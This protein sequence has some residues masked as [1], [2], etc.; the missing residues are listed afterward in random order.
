MRPG[1]IAATALAL[2]ASVAQAQDTRPQQPAGQT[3]PIKPARQLRFT[4]T[5]G[6]WMSL[7]ISPDGRTIVFDL[8]GDL[9]SMAA[10][11]G[12]AT[13]I[14]GGMGFDAQ[15]A[16]AP[17]GG[18]I[19]F[20]SDR[21]GAENLWIARPDGSNARQVS[22]GDD[23]TV[24]TSPAWSTDGKS[25]F[26]SRFRADLNN[27]ELWR[28]DLTGGATLVVP[29]KDGKDRH[30][31]LGAEATR[32]G[33]YL[34]FARQNAAPVDDAITPWTIVRRDLRTGVETIL[35]AGP[36][37]RGADKEAFFRPLPSPDGKLLAYAMRRGTQTQ[38][39]LRDLE[40][41]SDRLI[42]AELDRDNA[43]ASAWQDVI[44][45][46]AFTPDGSAL[47]LT[48]AGGF[49][50]VTLDGAITRLPFEA[51]VDLDVGPT[52]R[53]RL[54]EP[55][56]PV[57]ARLIQAPAV[58]P[59]GKS[60]AFSTLGRLYIRPANG[61]IR[62]LPTPAPAFQPSWSPDGKR[63]VFV[64]WTEAGGGAVWTIDSAGAA[65]PKQIS[66]LPAYYTN[67][68]FTPDG[69]E[70]LTIRSPA[71]A[72][73]Q[74]NFDWG[75]I[76]D[77]ELAAFPK[78]GGDARVVAGGRIGGRPHF[79][80]TANTVFLTA[81]DGLNAVDM[82]TGTRRRVIQVKGAG[83]YFIEGSVPVD[84]TRISPDGQW[85]IVQ[86]AQQL[87]LLP[88]PPKGAAEIDLE[89]PGTIKRRLSDIG[90]DYIGFG[91]NNTIDWAVGTQFRRLPLTPELLTAK[92]LP[93]A[94]M[95]DI[96]VEVPRD[97]PQ[98]SIVLHGARVLT[99]ANSNR[100]IEDADIL[101]TGDRIVAV[102]PRGTLKLPADAVVRDVSGKTIV[103]GF[104]DV[105]DHIG[106]IR[107]DVLSTEEWG[108]RA[109]LAYGVTTSFDPSTLSIDMIGYQ[110]MIDAGLV[111]GPRLRSTGPALFSMNRFQSLDEV[112]T[113]LRRY[114]DAYGLTNIKE[115]RT[116]NR[117]VRQW[118][119]IA[120]REL[121]LLP[122]TE[123]AL[124][125]KL[126]LSQIIDGYAGNEH[127]LTADPLGADV[128]G[129]LAAMHT[130]YT[131]TLMVTN[132]GPPADDWFVAASDP[133]NDKR[134]Q[135][136]WPPPAIEQKL[137][138]RTWRALDH[139]RFPAV[140]EGA[141]RVMRAGGL[142]GIGAHGEVPGLGF[143]WEMEAHVMGGMSPMEVLH[144][145]TAGSAE[146][147]GRLDD[148][149]T[150]E[151]G[152]LADILVLDR[153]PVGDIRN[154]QSVSE[155]MRG[156]HLYAAATLDEIWPLARPLPAPWFR[157]G[158]TTEHWLPGEPK[159]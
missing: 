110:D 57:R 15:P 109:R 22:F 86:S 49:E 35:I 52:T 21:S 59:D 89:K 116:G 128:T 94:H 150:I 79:S 130:S 103:P 9:Y 29:V 5:T 2:L 133:K 47:L 68:V 17:D 134:T 82:T 41:G 99:M 51:P 131:T 54:H 113:V 149:G 145:A 13:R 106:T 84:D 76:R 140:A 14:S 71:A 155:V 115:Y 122:T 142:V 8:L 26:V 91:P 60:I 111:L 44:P 12:H 19:A 141:A 129:L 1:A 38:L 118:I 81:A 20:V 7:D 66:D 117:R 39:R 143:H 159:Q 58:S 153:D 144:A 40:T 95:T 46:Y 139:Y 25:V 70:I 96:V 61:G 43:Q 137:T 108:L 64:T 158:V 146:T 97:R 114:R 88:A 50:R 77:G 121:G 6:T 83:Y 87:Y 102:G 138:D 90:A 30:S 112:R 45:R 135:A 154:T 31:T 125:F 151:A 104:I 33:R 127:A 93:K 73:Q 147:I 72:R 16:F 10:T 74:S 156:G 18:M 69:R 24:L 56:G 100:V 157:Q 53:V 63:I 75:K 136:F 4:T 126:D 120:A 78:A 132:G 85:L 32:D 124:S 80:N 23:D 27:Y 107:R 105:H 28:Y 36:G 42:V 67:P 119:A 37:S 123:G 148:L 65:M 48:R 101:V 3:L 34:Y 55:N 92:S 98:G 11:G 62:H 152:K